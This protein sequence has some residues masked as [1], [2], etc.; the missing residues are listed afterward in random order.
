MEENKKLTFEAPAMEI[1]ILHI[2]NVINPS[3]GGF[4]GDMD[5]FLEKEPAE[6]V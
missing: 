1:I 2:E 3:S 4:H 5:F 6:K